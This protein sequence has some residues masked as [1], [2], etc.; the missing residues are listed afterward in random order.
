MKNEKAFTLIEL[1]VVIAIIAI[2]AAMLLPALSRARER[3]RG[4][5]CINSLRQIGLA[6]QMYASDHNGTV[7]YIIDYVGW[8]GARNWGIYFDYLPHPPSNIY[9]CPSEAP[10]TDPT[11][12]EWYPDDAWSTS[13]PNVAQVAAGYGLWYL[14]SS[15][16][17]W[18][19]ARY[20]NFPYWEGGRVGPRIGYTTLWD[21]RN[22]QNYPRSFDSLVVNRDTGDLWPWDIQQWTN[23]DVN[24][25]NRGF[26][27]RHTGRGNIQF[28]DGHVE[29][30]DGYRM[31][32]AVNHMFDSSATINISVFD[33]SY[34]R[35][36][37][38]IEG[39]L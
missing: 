29:A 2:L 30:A 26:H 22:P 38:N 15:A 31:A 34:V 35:R 32:D 37:F 20:E 3:A 28:A 36:Q 10:H 17:R 23:P 7:A 19:A 11:E 4:A 9:V 16:D 1:L 8:G 24:N 18:N 21:I 13:I 25:E 39:N 27:L 14:G 33:G 6:E 12:A 5:S